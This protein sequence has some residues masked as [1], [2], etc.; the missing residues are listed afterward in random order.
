MLRVDVAPAAVGEPEGDV[1]GGDVVGEPGPAG[2]GVG[3]V[4]GDEVVGDEADACGDGDPEGAGL[5]LVA[6]GAD[7]E[8]LGPPAVGVGAPVGTP[9]G[10]PVGAKGG[11]GTPCPAPVPAV[12]GAGVVLTLPVVEDGVGLAECRTAG[13]GSRPPGLSGCPIKLKASST[14]YPTQTTA[15]TASAQVTQVRRR[16]E[17]STNTGEC[18]SSSTCSLTGGMSPPF[19]GPA[20]PLRHP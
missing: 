6:P 4:V 7:G 11:T 18:T 5:G 20:P 12:G 10:A 14:T 17:G 2:C 16:P 9:A 19:R 1:V 3:D 8:A 13:S 15:A